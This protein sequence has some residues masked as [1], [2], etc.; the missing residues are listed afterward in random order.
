MIIKCKS[1]KKE[2]EIGKHN[3]LMWALLQ[4]EI[5]VAS[6]CRGN[7]ACKWCKIN[8]LSGND[9][10]SEKTIYETN[11]NLDENQRL[12]CQ[13]ISTGDIEIDTTYW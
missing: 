2:I 7:G 5:P 12:A 1:L 13:C 4:H 10:L 9:Y 3:A 11:A 8:I 6:S